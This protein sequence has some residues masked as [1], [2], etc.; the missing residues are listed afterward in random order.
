MSRVATPQQIASTSTTTIPQEK[1]ARRAYEKWCKRGCT[2]GHD[3][4][5]WLEAEKELRSEMP[6]GAA[7]AQYRR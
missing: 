5:D 3:Q 6:R 4:Q 7:S 2:H 1:I